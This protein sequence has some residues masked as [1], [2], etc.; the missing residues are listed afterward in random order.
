M[1]MH[2]W[3]ERKAFVP[4]SHR[5]LKD[6]VKLV[7]RLKG[8]NRQKYI[9][10]CLCSLLFQLQ[11]LIHVRQSVKMDIDIFFGLTLSL[12]NSSAAPGGPGL[13][14]SR[15]PQTY[16]YCHNLICSLIGGQAFLTRSGNH[17]PPIR[18]GSEVT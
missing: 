9:L 17:L 5:I 13:R 12:S 14:G 10:P 7:M 1:F 4:E 16:I 11:T 3:T 15:N 2:N 6:N 18:T 8:K